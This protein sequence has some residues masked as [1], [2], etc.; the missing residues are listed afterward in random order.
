MKKA[1]GKVIEKDIAFVKAKTQEIKIII[2][3]K[4]GR[5]YDY[6]NFKKYKEENCIE[7]LANKKYI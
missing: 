4:D 6:Q 1:S 3:N 2:D 5:I 7:E